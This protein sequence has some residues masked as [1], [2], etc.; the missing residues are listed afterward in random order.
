MTELATENRPF[1]MLTQNDCP[2]CERLKLMLDKP[3]RGQFGPQIRAIHRQ[4]QAEEFSALVEQYGIQ[5]TP[6]LLHLPSGR[7]LLNTGGLG[8]VKAFLTQG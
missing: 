3:L 5:T 7:V 1:V 6:A 8:E 4:E 2:Q